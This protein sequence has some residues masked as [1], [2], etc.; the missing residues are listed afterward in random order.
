MT[1]TEV[2]ELPSKFCV[3]EV[4]KPKDVGKGEKPSPSVT[5]PDGSLIF[6]LYRSPGNF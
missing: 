2:Y 4:G 6:Q 1:H 5:C 3:G